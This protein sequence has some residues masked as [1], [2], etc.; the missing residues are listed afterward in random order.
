MDM[1]GTRATPSAQ[2]SAI[3][4]YVLVI[5]GTWAKR[6]ANEPAW[7]CLNLND[8]TNFCA[9]LEHEFKGTPLEGS[10]WRSVPG[11]K[12]PFVWDAGNTHE[13]R[14]AAA[15][16]LAQ[17]LTHIVDEDPSARIHLI[18]HS[19]GG[20]VVLKALELY[21]A[22][23]EDQ[24]ASKLKKT[25]LEVGPQYPLDRVNIP[26]YLNQI[27]SSIVSRVAGPVVLEA[28]RKTEFFTKLSKKFAL[29]YVPGLASILM[30]WSPDILLNMMNIT[31]R[32]PFLR[33]EQAAWLRK[34]LYSAWS[35]LR[36]D[37]IVDI[38]AAE[39]TKNPTINRLGSIVFLG[40]PFY[41]KTWR[42][43]LSSRLWFWASR[44]V[45][46]VTLLY[47]IGSAAALRHCPRFR[48]SLHGIQLVRLE[49]IRLAYNNASHLGRGIRA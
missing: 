11:I 35:P 31:K 13:H 21:L 42:L 27:L 48:L 16:D 44:L 12:W 32:L 15:Q 34:R 24:V 39:I 23:C 29:V 14:V 3:K 49:S 9:R 7:Y 17:T 40:T 5:H 6:Q 18:A 43:Q 2:G 37:L 10:V 45:A 22:R 30:P 1:N 8:T 33:P 25:N 20:N 46:G 47:D 41:R 38:L 19:H 36:F 28:L 26:D 4:H